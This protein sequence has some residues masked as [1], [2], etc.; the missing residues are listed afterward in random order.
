MCLGSQETQLTTDTGNGLLD[1]SY[2]I[3]NRHF[4]QVHM[5]AAEIWFC[6]FTLIMHKICS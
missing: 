5:C 1:N 6:T 4:P 2:Y 3:T